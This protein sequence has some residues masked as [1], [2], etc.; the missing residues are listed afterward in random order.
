MTQQKIIGNGKIWLPAIVLV[1]LLLF[2]LFNLYTKQARTD[3]QTMKYPRTMFPIGVDTIVEGT[4][5][6]IDTVYH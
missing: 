4:F 5:K 1:P 3:L 2:G 6:R